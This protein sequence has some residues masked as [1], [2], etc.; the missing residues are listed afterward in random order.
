MRRHVIC[1]LQILVSSFCSAIC[2][3]RRVKCIAC[4]RII[5][6][7]QHSWC[8]LQILQHCRITKD[9]FGWIRLEWKRRHWM[10]L[11]SSNNFF[12]YLYKTG[13]K[14]KRCHKTVESMLKAFVKAPKR[15]RQINILLYNSYEWVGECIY[16]MY[17]PAEVVFGK[18]S[19][20]LLRILRQT[21]I[22]GEPVENDGLEQ[23]VISHLQNL[24]HRLPDTSELTKNIARKRKNW[25]R[26]RL[27][28]CRLTCSSKLA[29]LMRVTKIALLNGT[30]WL[31]MQ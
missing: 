9:V 21:Y 20:S 24:K 19:K 10:L 14:L 11:V 12:L 5:Q 7:K 23:D 17:S 3:M 16:T 2:V 26:N 28:I 30:Y 15:L 6:S 4:L 27:T 22:S 29:S 8:A 1:L 31:Y 13:E 18:L 25:G